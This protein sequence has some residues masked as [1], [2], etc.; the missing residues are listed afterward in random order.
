MIPLPFI[1]PCLRHPGLA[2]GQETDMTSEHGDVYERVTNKVIADLEQ[3][4]R[5]WSGNNAGSRITLPLRH[6]GDA[7]LGH[8]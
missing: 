2:D 5:P 6:C 3:G 7:I 1:R 8:Q 4:V